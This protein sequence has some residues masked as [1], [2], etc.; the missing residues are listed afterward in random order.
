MKHKATPFMAFTAASA[1][2]FFWFGCEDKSTRT[3]ETRTEDPPCKCPI[4]EVKGL[5][6]GSYT[7]NDEAS[8]NWVTN[9]SG[10]KATASREGI[11]IEGELTGADQQKVKVRVEY[12][13]SGLTPDN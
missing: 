13:I 1:L 10:L 11:V 8:S 5:K 3:Y 6:A 12:T 7:A 9:M 2:S 4:P